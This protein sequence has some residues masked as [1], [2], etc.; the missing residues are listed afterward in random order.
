[1]PL[2]QRPSTPTRLSRALVWLAAATALAGALFASLDSEWRNAAPRTRSSASPTLDAR[3]DG[4]AW[5]LEAAWFAIAR[6]GLDEALLCTGSTD[7][8][9]GRAGALRLSFGATPHEPRRELRTALPVRRLEAGANAPT[10]ADGFAQQR[11]ELEAEFEW[12]GGAHGLH[13]VALRSSRSYVNTH[14]TGSRGGS[15]TTLLSNSLLLAEQQ[16]FA[17]ADLGA[18]LVLILHLAPA[19]SPR[20]ALHDPELWRT[21]CRT[22]AAPTGHID[23][24]LARSA[25]A[26]LDPRENAGPT[27]WPNSLASAAIA[28][29]LLRDA[30]LAEFVRASGVRDFASLSV[31]S[32]ET[33]APS[34]RAL[35]AST[36]AA[37]ACG[38]APPVIP[39]ADF[40]FALGL[41]GL[42]VQSEPSAAEHLARAL[43]PRVESGDAGFGMARYLAYS[44][45]EPASDVWRELRS[46]SLRALPQPWRF[47]LLSRITLFAFALAPWLAGLAFVHLVRP[48]PSRPT[49]VSRVVLGALLLAGLVQATGAALLIAFALVFWTQCVEHLRCDENVTSTERAF[50]GLAC[51]ATLFAALVDIGWM[52]SA[53][54][55]TSLAHSAPLLAWAVL[56]RWLWRD[57]S[58]RAPQR[59][60]RALAFALASFVAFRV[61]PSAAWEWIGSLCALAALAALAHFALAGR[62]QLN[63]ARN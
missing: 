56:G 44:P 28:S 2:P 27:A 19:S 52:V 16:V 12:R 59:F 33:S 8:V 5:R 50:A 35:S 29:L 30:T 55:S 58:W 31:G 9:D 45:P 18:G 1:M 39:S 15:T 54:W 13:L 61:A 48:G 34:Q 36:C 46:V 38:E 37:L 11:G 53:P 57:A 24:P 42:V 62:A 51:G 49:G 6:E 14:W 7:L 4:A 60:D 40:A 26:Q 32:A 23:A 20:A 43:R 21:R 3:A 47:A 17:E 22:L 10:L 25:L 63:A 41:R